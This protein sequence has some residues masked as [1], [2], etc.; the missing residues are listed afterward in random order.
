MQLNSQTSFGAEQRCRAFWF[1]CQ[2]FFFDQSKR[3]LSAPSAERLHWS[4]GRR[5]LTET[6]PGSAQIRIP[7]LDILSCVH[8]GSVAVATVP[9][10]RGAPR[11]LST[12]A[13]TRSCRA[14]GLMQRCRTKGV[15]SRLTGPGGPH[16]TR[17]ITR[18]R[19]SPAGRN[20]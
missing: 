5:D 7:T 19:L 20:Q 15:A 17:W 11:L 13:D 14:D 2:L 12:A 6:R 4:F 8:S 16:E 10:A 3:F 18:D 9:P 1:L